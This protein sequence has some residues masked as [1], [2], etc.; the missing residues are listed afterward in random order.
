MTATEI[1]DMLE[2]IGRRATPRLSPAVDL[3]AET[4][5][6]RRDLILQAIRGT[7][8]PRRVEF[9]APDGT[10]LALELNSSRITDVYGSSTG[11]L[12]DFATEPRETIVQ[13]LARLVSDLAL[14]GNP[15]QMVSL[16]P[17]GPTEADDVGITFTEMKTACA[18]IELRE[19]EPRLT[20]L[21]TPDPEPLADDPAPENE[22]LAAAF[23]EGSERFAMGRFLSGPASTRRHDGLCADGQPLHPSTG[24]LD[25][26]AKDLAGWDADAGGHLPH[27]Q[28]IVMRPS[29]GKGAALALLRDGQDNA[30]AIHDARKLGAVV[31]LW[32]SLR[33]ADP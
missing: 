27:P 21:Q 13:K 15:I 25:R 8:L 28:L 10:L 11:E 29:G 6:A 7:V 12:P 31:A 14:A 2:N 19:D 1:I 24:L 9:T 4:P 18:V 30:A 23:F 26:F 22:G 33:G 3:T 16:Q 20:V 5:A 17:D 32:K